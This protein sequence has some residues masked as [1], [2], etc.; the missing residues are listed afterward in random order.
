MSKI[1]NFI[2]KI[3]FN[4]YIALLI[5]WNFIK[6]NAIRIVAV[7]AFVLVL[8]GVLVKTRDISSSKEAAK[9]AM[10]WVSSHIRTLPQ[11]YH[12]SAA[13]AKEAAELGIKLAS[14]QTIV[15]AYLKNV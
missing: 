7:L 10:F 8:G 2:I 14:N 9:G 4:V 15:D 12:H 3:G 5:I 6:N 1:K 11:G 13:K